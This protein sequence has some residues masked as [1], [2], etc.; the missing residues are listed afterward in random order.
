MKQVIALA[1]AI[2]LA[3]SVT[4]AANPPS[5]ALVGAVTNGQIS[6]AGSFSCYGNDTNALPPTPS[7]YIR[8]TATGPIILNLGTFTYQASFGRTLFFYKYTGTA[9]LHFSNATSGVLHWDFLPTGY[10]VAEFARY[11]HFSNYSQ[12]YNAGEHLLTLSFTADFGHCSLPVKG[13]FH[14]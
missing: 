2:V 10:K 12:T 4:K 7:T 9:S 1:L 6:N 11:R 13:I 14:G 3:P 5:T 8:P